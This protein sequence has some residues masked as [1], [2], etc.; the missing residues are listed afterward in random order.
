MKWLVFLLIIFSL[1]ACGTLSQINRNRDVPPLNE[2]D[3]IMD[4]QE[5]LPDFGAAPE[6]QG[7]VWLNTDM[8]LRLAD[9]RGKVVLLDMWTFG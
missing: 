6:L 2:E 4:D 8:P 5:T 7:D 9:L 1:T 3:R